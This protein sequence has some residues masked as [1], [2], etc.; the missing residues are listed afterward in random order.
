MGASRPEFDWDDA[1]I[2]HIARHAVRP[3]EAEQVVCGAFLP[4]HT[5]EH[6]AEVRY[7]ELGE[8]AAGRILVVVWTWRR[9]KVR[10]VTAFPPNKRWK[11]LWR[12]RKKGRRDG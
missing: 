7:T 12:K 9:G 1:N 11:A 6:G 10:V 4:L 5:E 3:A 2:G 8:T